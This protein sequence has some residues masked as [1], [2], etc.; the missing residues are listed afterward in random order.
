MDS[1][2]ERLRQERLRRGFDLQQIAE[3]TKINIVMLEAIEADDLESLPGIFFTRSFVRQYARALDLD[4]ASFEPEL[5]RLA[6]CESVPTLEDL[7]AAREDFD[8]PPMRAARPSSH[9]LRPLLLSLAALLFVGAVC[10]AIFT[11]WQR[12]REF[13][14]AASI[15]SVPAPQPPPR[16][17]VQ[18]AAVPS[19]PPP[20][21]SPAA[22][23][24]SEPPAEA[25]ANPVPPTAA[26]TEPPAETTAN[27]A[28][29]APQ[30]A[31][32]ARL[33][34]RLHATA[35]DWVR[36]AVDGTFSFSA[37]LQPG[38]IRDVDATRLVQ[39]RVGDAAALEVFWNGQPVAALGPKGQARNVE[40]TPDG[41]N[42]LAPRPPTPEPPAD[43][44]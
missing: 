9:R 42:I 12:G 41:F 16:P 20:A 29:P 30:P 38:E 8:V 22:S 34:V 31:P 40:F 39:L 17:A 14:P 18:P 28:P 2:G 25:A 37:T 6:A 10:A 43:A 33:H 3:F 32:A 24:T 19:Q 44:P 23:A 26:T 5:N 11:Y 7:P 21:P 13:K 35:A 27:P 1:I 4:E 15:L 36:V